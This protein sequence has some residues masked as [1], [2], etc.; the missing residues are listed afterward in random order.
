MPI[1]PLQRNAGSGSQTAMLSFMDGE[2]MKKNIAGF[3]GSAIG[4]SFR[5]Y[6]EEV[7]EQG[8]V[9]MLE[10]DGVYPNKENISKRTYPIV[11]N[12]Y[13]VYDKKN[14]NS[15][16]RPFV[17]WML[18]KEGQ[19]IIEETGYCPIGKDSAR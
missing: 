4:F 2:K 10:V 3:L 12:F 8:S 14:G 19:R 15:N 9:K 7:V 5:Y 16:I 13:A 17:K 18:S 1:N 6:V 11:S